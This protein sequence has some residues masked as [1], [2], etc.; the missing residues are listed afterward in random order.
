LAAAIIGSANRRASIENRKT[1]AHRPIK[2]S[3]QVG[4]CC[5]QGF[6]DT[7]VEPVELAMGARGGCRRIGR[8]GEQT[9]L[10]DVVAGP[11]KASRPLPRRLS[12]LAD[13]EDSRGDDEER[14]PSTRPDDKPAKQ[15]DIS[16]KN[17]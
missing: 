4:I 3:I 14:R 11:N 13:F 8:T 16:V 5:K 17:R 9:D 2:F 12:I 10:A 15:S 1:A 7:P 6:Y